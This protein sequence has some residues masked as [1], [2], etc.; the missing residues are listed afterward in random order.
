MNFTDYVIQQ[1]RQN[2]IETLAILK[3]VIRQAGELPEYSYRFQGEQNE[4]TDEV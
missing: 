2:H 1:Y 3:D 4:R